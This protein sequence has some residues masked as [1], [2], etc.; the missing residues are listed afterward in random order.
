MIEKAEDNIEALDSIIE[1][2][3]AQ[4]QELFDKEQELI[5]EG[6][7]EVAVECWWVNEASKNDYFENGLVKH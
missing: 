1:S 7:S 4:I 6:T 3:D 2:Y 5:A